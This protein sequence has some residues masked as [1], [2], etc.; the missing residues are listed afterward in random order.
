M[1]RV[2]LPDSRTDSEW[3]LTNGLGGFASAT[4]SGSLRRRYHGYLVAALPAPLGRAVMLSGV[5]ER[6]VA[7]QG[8]DQH[9]ATGTPTACNASRDRYGSHRFQ[10]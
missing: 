6:I 8:D 1:Q 7:D 4:L 3:L 5:T 2:E 10:A 9:G